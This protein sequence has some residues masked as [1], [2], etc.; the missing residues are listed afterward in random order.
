MEIAVAGPEHSHAKHDGYHIDKGEA[1][2]HRTVQH[3]PWRCDDH[4]ASNAND[5]D[6]HDKSR[7]LPR[8]LPRV[9][10]ARWS[11]RGGAAR[12]QSGAEPTYDTDDQKGYTDP[13]SQNCH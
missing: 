2:R 8:I 3:K 6:G 7:S 9:Q 1:T 11:R 4:A 12:P 13:N 5:S 10:V